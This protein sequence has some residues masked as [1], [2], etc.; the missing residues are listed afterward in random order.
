MSDTQCFNQARIELG[1]GKGEL[2]NTAM[3]AVVA[4]AQELKQSFRI[5]TERRQAR[6][7]QAAVRNSFQS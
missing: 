2:T 7:M 3:H 4:R 6:L 5:E 1:Y